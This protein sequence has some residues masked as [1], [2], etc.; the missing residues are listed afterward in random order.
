MIGALIAGILYK[1]TKNN[2]IAVSG[3]IFGTGILGG[4]LAFPIANLIMGK[5]VGALFF[6]A[7]FLISTLGGSLIAF[8]ILR[9][10]DLKK[11]TNL[12]KEA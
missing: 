10:L 6:V 12:S 5:K 11:L 4:L 1:K 2:L 3:E 7:P 9:V 8:F